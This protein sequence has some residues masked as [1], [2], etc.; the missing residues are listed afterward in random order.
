MD[1]SIVGGEG[2]EFWTSSLETLRGTTWATKLLATRFKLGVTCSDI[3][4]NYQFSE[5]LEMLRN[6]KFNHWINY[7]NLR[8]GEWHSS[9]L[10]FGGNQ[11]T[12]IPW[13]TIAKYSK[14]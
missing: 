9:P 8:L 7:K 6:D 12:I 13:I 14:F 10:Q 5:Q 4:I 2:L 3:M 11:H 1:N